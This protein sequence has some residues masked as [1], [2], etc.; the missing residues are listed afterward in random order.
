MPDS[1]LPYGP[2]PARLLCPWDF[3]G[4]N[5]G[6]GCHF[7]LQGIFPTQGLNPHFLCHLHWQVGSLS[8][9]PPGN[10]SSIFDVLSHI[11]FSHLCRWI[12]IS[13]CD[14]LLFLILILEQFEHCRTL[15]KSEALLSANTL[16]VI[17]S[18]W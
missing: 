10:C 7:P 5:T 12:V 17:M 6:V 13:H 2:E 8:L 18:S 15:S 9:A 14:S 11:H 3:P 16:G 4:K 1:L